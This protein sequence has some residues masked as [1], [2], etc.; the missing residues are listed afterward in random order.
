MK[1]NDLIFTKDGQIEDHRSGRHYYDLFY[2]LESPLLDY[3][4]ESLF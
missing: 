2:S 3:F 1:M 4:N